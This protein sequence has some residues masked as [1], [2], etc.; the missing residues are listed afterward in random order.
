VP[1]TKF[2]LLIAVAL[3]LLRDTQ[4]LCFRESS[5]H[6]PRPGHATRVSRRS[7]R[8]TAVS[9]SNFVAGTSCRPARVMTSSRQRQV[10]LGDA[11]S[12]EHNP[13][14]VTAC[15]IVVDP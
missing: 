14:G 10:F 15:F 2:E 7:L 9:N 3:K 13:S 12:T 11:V 5:T 8:A 4:G 6:F 1:A